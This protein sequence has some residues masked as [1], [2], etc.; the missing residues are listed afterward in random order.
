MGDTTEG[1]SES[2]S[3]IESDK[4]LKLFSDIIKHTNVNVFSLRKVK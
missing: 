3:G 2:E 4:V 1:N